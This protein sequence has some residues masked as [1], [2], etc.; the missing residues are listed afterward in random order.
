MTIDLRSDTVTRPT[1]A[2]LEAMWSANVGDD[3]FAED[4]SINALEKK[5]AEMFGMEAAL[6]CPSGTMT[7]QI[8]IKVHTQPGD[9]VICHRESHIYCYEGG[10]IAFNSGAQVRLIEGNNGQLTASDIAANINP[11]DSHYSRTT[12]VAVEN[13]TNRGGGGTYPFEELRKIGKA[14]HEHGLKYHLDGARLMNAIV[15]NN[16]NPKHYGEIFDSISLC[17]SKGLGCPVG[18]LLLGTTEFIKKAHRYR[19]IM[20]G[21]MRQAGFLAAAAIYALDN[22]VSRLAEDHKRAKTIGLELEKQSWV[23]K[24]LPCETNIL[25]FFVPDTTTR[26]RFLNHLK[27]AHIHAM[28]FGPQSIRF[29]THLDFNDEMMEKVNEA[30]RS[31]TA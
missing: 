29:V 22:N 18:S 10:G 4:P 19:K 9:E 15:A 21:G 14:T 25:I 13:T 12:L 11:G 28:A 23:N 7:N 27:A 17:L 16:E 20:G 24:V 1:P 31:F 3:V 6:F 2:M 26:D 8:A 30:I 5:A